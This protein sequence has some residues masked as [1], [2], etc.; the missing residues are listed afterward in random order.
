M[1]KI[2]NEFAVTQVYRMYCEFK[3]DHLSDLLDD[4]V[5]ISSDWVINKLRGKLKVSEF[6]SQKMAT[7][8]GAIDAKRLS[9]SIEIV[10][11]KTKTSEDF[12]LMVHSADNMDDEVVSAIKV[13][14]DPGEHYINQI[15]ILKIKSLLHSRR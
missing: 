6:L 15:N 5:I 7:L 11:F 13:M 10:N 12:L 4:D 3:V 8:K 2:T 1:K 14:L 9:L